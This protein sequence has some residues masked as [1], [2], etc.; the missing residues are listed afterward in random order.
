QLVGEMRAKLEEIPGIEANFS[1]PIKDNIEENISGINGQV[2][3][4]IFGDD[5]DVLRRTAGEVKHAVAQVRGVADLAVVH[6]AELPQVHIAIDR[7]AIARYGL[8]VAD[9][10]EVIETLIGGKAAT[11]LWEGERRF[12][13]TVRLSEAARSNLSRIPDVKVTTPD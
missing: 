3:I 1:Q 13:V 12:D 10:E 11:Q 6:A 4:K 5:L 7:S 8:N 2:A 9:V